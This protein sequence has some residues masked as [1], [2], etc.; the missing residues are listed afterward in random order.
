MAVLEIHGTADP[1]APYQGGKECGGCYS[2]MLGISLP[3]DRWPCRPVRDV[4]HDAA[5]TNGC[6]GTELV[7]AG[8]EVATVDDFPARM[9]TAVQIPSAATAMRTNTY[10]NVSPIRARLGAVT[11][12]LEALMQGHRSTTA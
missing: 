5:V 4:L 1:C 2:K 8:G 3:H 7:A 10:D 11:T 9:P 12:K 6:S